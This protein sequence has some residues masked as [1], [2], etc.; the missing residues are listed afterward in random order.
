MALNPPS[1][2]PKNASS[3]LDP[4]LFRDPSAEYRGTPFWAWNS[5]LKTPRLFEQIEAM[6]Q[7]GMGGFHMHARVG[8]DTPYLSDEF[9]QRVR[10]CVLKARELK[11]L[12]WRS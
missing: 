2:Y 4:A 11:M 10:E 9:M 1:L 5:A 8:L 3:A 6:K 7:M 12:A